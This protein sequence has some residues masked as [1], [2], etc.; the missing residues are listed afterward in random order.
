MRSLLTL[1]ALTYA[2]TG[3]IVAAVTTSLPE[4]L[5]GVRNW[6]YRFCWLRDATITLQALLYSGF[7][8]EAAAWRKWLLRA[9]AGDPAEMQIM[10]GV[11]GERRGDARPDRC[12][13]GPVV[14]GE[15][16]G[17]EADPAARPATPG[18][19]PGHA[20]AARP[21]SGRHA[22]ARTSSA[23]GTAA[24]MGPGSWRR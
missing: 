17:A 4:Q 24:T 22:R 5:G 12:G 7:A 15:R 9:I 3:G 20:T 8:E 21:A 10:Y 6:D 14:R 19:T 18:P 2:P 1:K 16:L 13:T 11:A 23:I